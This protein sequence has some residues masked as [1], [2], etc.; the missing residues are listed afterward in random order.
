LGIRHVSRRRGSGDRHLRPNGIDDFTATLNWNVTQPTVGGGNIN[1]LPTAT[2][3]P[4]LNLELR[5][6][7]PDVVGFTIGGALADAGY[8][9]ASTNDNIEHLY[10]TADL[11]A[12]YY[13]LIVHGDASTTVPY[14]ISYNLTAVPEPTGLV[15]LGLGG[16]AL[17]RR[18]RK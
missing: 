1:T 17:L 5:P 16:V 11:P 2:I 10:S 8:Q 3:F 6:A 14:G 15:M 13:A 4:N 18:R 12:G 9:S 7:M